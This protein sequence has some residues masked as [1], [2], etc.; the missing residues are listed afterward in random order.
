CYTGIGAQYKTGIGSNDT[1]SAE[2]SLGNDRAQS[3]GRSE[4]S[5]EFEEFWSYYPRRVGKQA[6]YKAWTA[7]LKKK[8]KPEKIIA[9]SWNYGEYCRQLGTD[10][11]FMKH[12][13]TFLGPNSPFTEFVEGLPEDIG[14]TAK[15]KGGGMNGADK[16]DNG[17]PADRFRETIGF[18]E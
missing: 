3:T 17:Q 8:Y 5:T 14:S 4:Y 11:K 10:Q 2:K 13:A 15:H 9:A 18:N 1:T 7:Q 12:A 6:A 16:Q